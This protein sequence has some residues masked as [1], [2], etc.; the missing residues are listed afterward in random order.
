MSNKTL[1]D[2]VLWHYCFIPE[3]DLHPEMKQIFMTILGES[4]GRCE[5]SILVVSTFPGTDFGGFCLLDRGSAPAAVPE[6]PWKRS[7]AGEARR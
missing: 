1:N 4:T 3:T 7:C 6:I 5:S 2:L